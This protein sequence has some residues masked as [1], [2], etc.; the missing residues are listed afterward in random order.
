VEYALLYTFSTIPQTLAA[1]L[2]VLAAFVLYRL[3]SDSQTL[4]DDA[5]AL[6]NQFGPH[7]PTRI[8]QAD[9][10]L[11][12]LLGSQQYEKLLAEFEDRWQT[13]RHALPE[14]SM[15]R[16]IYRKL[17]ANL[18]AR[19]RILATLK[20]AFWVTAAIIVASL[21]LLCVANRVSQD[22]DVARGV[23][24][25]GVASTALCLW[26]YWRLVRAA[27]WKSGDAIA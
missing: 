4:W 19:R 5:H 11:G 20:V 22:V 16:V 10:T 24:F 21:V 26:L 1:A 18:E 8:Y 13:P 6:I 14:T 3:Q 15:H 2:G 23:L 17:K 27:L 7:E 12:E 9:R 25:A